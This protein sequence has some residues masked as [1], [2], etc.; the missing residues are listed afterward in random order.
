MVY[1]DGGVEKEI[2]IPSSA[3]SQ[4]VTNQAI[5]ISFDNIPALSASDPTHGS[6]N[7]GFT[8][9][10]GDGY[11]DELLKNVG[12]TLR[13]DY[14][15]NRNIACGIVQFVIN[16]SSEMYCE[17]ICGEPGT[18]G[19][20]YLYE[21]TFVRFV[22]A[23]SDGSYIPKQLVENVPKSGY[24][25]ANFNNSGYTNFSTPQRTGFC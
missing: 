1:T 18:N 17:N 10:D 14:V 3:I 4:P 9:E 8:D 12:F 23:V 20:A 11:R 21:Q 19:G 13:F 2:P 25:M 22:N 6:K 15:K 16:P 24:L 5:T 7:I